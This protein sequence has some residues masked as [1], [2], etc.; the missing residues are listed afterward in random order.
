MYIV[1]SLLLL[2]PQEVKVS[3]ST[4]TTPAA[5]VCGSV[6]HVLQERI[7]MYNTAITNAKAAGESAKA[8][9]YDR[10]LKVPK[11]FLHLIVLSLPV[12]LGESR[13][14]FITYFFI[15][16]FKFLILL[17]FGIYLLLLLLWLLFLLFVIVFLPQTLQSM[18]A[19]VRKG[20]KI[21]EAEI[22]PPVASGNCGNA[23][24]PS[25]PP[26]SSPS[27]PEHHEES[28]SAVETSPVS[29]ENISVSTLPVRMSADLNL[30]L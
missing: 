10:G 3:S 28:D 22:P 9:R 7:V 14:F 25:A 6:E 27:P 1:M 17:I 12:P 19:A 2:R 13:F 20:G 15:Y 21:N 30:N 26:T 11:I 24:P 4:T 23:V 5:A 16:T 29:P 8:R 18:L